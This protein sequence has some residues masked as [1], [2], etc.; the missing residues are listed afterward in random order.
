MAILKIWGRENS[1]NVQKVLWLCEDLS[2][3]YERIDAGLT[4]GVNKT[5]QYLKINPNGLVP[6]IDDDGFILWESHAIMRYLIC[7]DRS[8]GE[9][10]S[11][12]PPGAQGAGVVDQWLDWVSTVAWPAMRPIFWGWVRLTPQERNLV[13]LEKSRQQMI[14]ALTILNTRLERCSYVCGEHFTLADIPLALIAFRWFNVPIERP[15]FVHINRW[16]ALL[17]ARAG[18]QRYCT[19][20]LT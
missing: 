7:R 18:F 9:A 12:Y 16:F 17:G 10:E 15:D 20:T 3:P 14:G 2:I 11:F 4:F 5:A 8:S 19:G 1:I 13:E 6:T